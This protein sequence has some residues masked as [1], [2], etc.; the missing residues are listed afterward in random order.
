MRSPD[1][2]DDVTQDTF[3]RAYNALDSFRNPDGHGFRSWL[4]TIA[5]NRAR[6]VL[7]SQARRPADSL[8]AL[9]DAEESS[10]Q[11][12]DPSETPTEFTERDALGL[13]I[14]AAIGQLPPDQRLVI[15]LSDVHNYSYEEIAEITGVAVGTV[16]SR[17]H[18]GRARLRTIILE[19]DDEPGTLPGSGSSNT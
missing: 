9:T 16:K 12:E 7:R 8:D 5:A 15:I 6:D 4:M 17:I 3:I 1:L 13:Q 10:W 19:M 18:R 11:P 14:E 2:A